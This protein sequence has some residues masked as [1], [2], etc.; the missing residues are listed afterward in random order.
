[1]YIMTVIYIF[2]SILDLYF[3]IMRQHTSASTHHISQRQTLPLG[4]PESSSHLGRFDGALA[5]L[6][7]EAELTTQEKQREKEV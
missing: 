6:G 4:C 3:P 2:Q 5:T 1:M 7:D